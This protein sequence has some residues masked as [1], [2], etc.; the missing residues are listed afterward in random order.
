MVSES[1]GKGK[2]EKGKLFLFRPEFSLERSLLL[3]GQE[4][5]WALE[6]KEAR[7]LELEGRRERRGG[8][9]LA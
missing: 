3:Y 5:R 4:N 8:P 7:G 1:R 9:D 6:A 2:E